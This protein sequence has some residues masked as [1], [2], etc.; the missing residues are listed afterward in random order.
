MR[1]ECGVGFRH[2]GLTRAS[3]SEK[4]NGSTAAP[5]FISGSRLV[6]AD[7]PRPGIFLFLALSKLTT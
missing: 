3:R 1:L 6:V 2:A 4:E 7:G 5:V